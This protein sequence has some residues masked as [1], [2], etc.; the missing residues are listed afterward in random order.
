LETPDMNAKRL[1][2]IP[3]LAVI[4]AVLL[5]VLASVNGEARKTMF[6][7]ALFSKGDGL[8]TLLDAVDWLNG[9]PPKAA[10]GRWFS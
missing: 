2:R 9:P 7:K 3:L 4:A 8:T 5:C 6:A 10:D 1:A